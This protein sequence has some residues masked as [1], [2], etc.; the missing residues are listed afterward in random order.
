ME[1]RPIQ[2]SSL[3][4]IPKETSRHFDLALHGAART[5]VE[6]MEN[7]RK[8]VNDCVASLKEFELGPVDMIVT[9]KACARESAHRYHPIGDEDPKSNLDLLMEQII[10]WAIV[11]YYKDSA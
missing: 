6:S 9:M 8:C 2:A 7:L 11:E 3:S 1:L 4:S 10:K 5:S